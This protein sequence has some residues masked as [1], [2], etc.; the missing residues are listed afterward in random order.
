MTKNLL[1]EIKH[2]VYFQETDA[3][4]LVYFGN[5]S[6]YIEMGFTE[7]FREHVGSLAVLNSQNNTFFVVKETKQSFH[8]SARYDDEIVIRT[9]LKSIK[10][11]SIAFYTEV[12]VGNEKCYSAETVLT[13]IDIR[14]KTPVKMP[15][16]ILDLHKEVLK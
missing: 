7:W 15:P 14:T 6:K 5:L 8:K 10:Y 1:C 2:R 12:L 16:E 9:E 4:H 13:P 3:G 11:F